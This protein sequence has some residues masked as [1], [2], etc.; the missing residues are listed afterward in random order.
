MRFISCNM[1][2]RSQRTCT[3][4][5]PLSEVGRSEVA[6]VARFLAAGGWGW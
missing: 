5:L 6:A 3:G 2:T 1:A 4:A